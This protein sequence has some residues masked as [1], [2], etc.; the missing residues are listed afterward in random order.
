[1]LIKCSACKFQRLL[2]ILKFLYSL[3]MGR[4]SLHDFIIISGMEKRARVEEIHVAFYYIFLEGADVAHWHRL[5]TQHKKRK[6]I[7]HFKTQR[8]MNISW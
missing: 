1:M 6:K 5:W 3:I 8:A 2:H 7:K 4:K